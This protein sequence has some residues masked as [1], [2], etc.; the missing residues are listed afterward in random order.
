VGGS[1][2]LPYIRLGVSDGCSKTVAF[3]PR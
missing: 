3:V 1:V 2:G